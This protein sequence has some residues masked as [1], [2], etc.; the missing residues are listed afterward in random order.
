MPNAKRK[1]HFVEVKFDEGRNVIPQ[2]RPKQNVKSLRK[3]FHV[4]SSEIQP[5]ISF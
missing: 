4:K 5:V 3:E 2:K 1:P